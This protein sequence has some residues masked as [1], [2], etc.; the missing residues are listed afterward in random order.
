MDG[1]NWEALAKPARREGAAAGRLANFVKH[2]RFP[3]EFENGHG[4]AGV[5]DKR[6]GGGQYNLAAERLGV[7]DWIHCASQVAPFEQTN[8]ETGAARTARAGARWSD[9]ALRLACI[10]F[11]GFQVGAEVPEV[12]SL[13][14]L[15]RLDV[16]RRGLCVWAWAKKLEALRATAA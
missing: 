8:G 16:L 1:R 4:G 3:S 13:G 5:R 2:P 6:E 9:Q 11:A 14:T 7:A 10:G 12:E 15:E